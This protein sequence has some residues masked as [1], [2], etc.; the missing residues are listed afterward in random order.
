MGSP[1]DI[2]LSTPG[3]YGPGSIVAWY[4][5]VAA[6]AISWIW[7]PAHRFQP[8]S[9]FIAAILYPFIAMVHF[10]IQLWN[11]PSDKTQYLR[12]NLMHILIGNG[13]E[14]P[15]SDQ[16]DYQYKNQVLFD[17]PGPDMFK[18]FPRVVTIDAALRIN[19][20][21]FWLCLIALGFLLVEHRKNWTEQ[22]LRGFNRVGKCLVAG[23]LLPLMNG[24]FLLIT[25]ADTRTFWI[26]LESTIFRFMALNMD[27]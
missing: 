21:C 17:K 24:I 10:A 8:T 23:I 11:F 12:A 26:P 27:L 14:G 13:D 1:S 15:V 18:I 2:V 22:Q 9:D 7:N 3:Y 5:V 19:D 4:C 6:T 25:C 16:Y 20:N